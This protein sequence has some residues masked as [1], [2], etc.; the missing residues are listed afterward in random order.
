[1][2]IASTSRMRSAARSQIALRREQLTSI[3]VDKLNLN[4]ARSP[5][6]CVQSTGSNGGEGG[7]DKDLS[8]S[9]TTYVYIHRRSGQGERRE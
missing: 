8:T 5:Q 9:Y 4:L 6:I 2:A 3:R 7:Q 1:M